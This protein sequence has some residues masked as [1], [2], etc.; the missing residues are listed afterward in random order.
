MEERVLSAG[1][2]ASG[3]RVTAVSELP[4]YR[5]RALRCVHLETGCEVLHLANQDPENLFAFVFRTPPPDDTGVAHI[6]EHAVLCGSRRFPLKD[7]FVVLLQSSMNTFLNALTYPDKTAYPAASRLHKDFFNLLDVYGDAVFFPLLRRE[8]FMQEGHHLEPADPGRPEGELA[9]VGVVLNEMKGAFSSP[10]ALLAQTSLRALFPDT[11]YGH[12]SGGD[13]EQIPELTYQ[14]FKEFHS[15]YYHPSNCRIFLYGDIPTAELLAFLQE[16][17]LSQFRHR[18]VA[19][20]LPEQ[21][22]WSRPRFVERRYPVAPEAPASGRSSVTLSWLTVPATE[23]LDLLAMEVATEALVGDVGSPLARALLESE[24]GEDLSPVTGLTA[25]VRQT[26]FSVGLRGTDP[27]KVEAVEKLVLGTLRRLAKEGIPPERLQAALHRVEFRNR[28][29]RRGGRPYSLR[30]LARAMRGWLHGA[31]PLATLEFRPWMKRLRSLLEE[32]PRLLEE[33]LLAQLADNPHRATVLV[34]P[35]QGLERRRREEERS[36]LAR[37]SAGLSAA[38]RRRLAEEL[39]AMRRF[40]AQRE[41]AD[42]KSGVPTLSIGDL[43]RQVERIPS[44]RRQEA[45]RPL[46]LHDLFTGGIIYLDL[47]FD[48]TGI[49][50]PLSTLVPLFG[51]AVCGSG[52]PGQPYHQT[53]SRLSLLTGGFGAGASAGSHAVSRRAGQRLLFRVKMLEENLEAALEIVFDLL[54]RAD[55]GDL[56]RLEKLVLELRND[57][58]SSLVPAGNHYAALRAASRFSEAAQVEER[59][60]GVTQLARIRDLAASMRRR[61][62]ETA[63]ALRRLR[64]VLVS[65]ERL[66]INLTCP[67]AAAERALAALRPGLRQLP[68]TGA[69]SQAVPGGLWEPEAASVG[70]GYRAEGLAVPAEVG[71]VAAVM[72]AA[73]F[74]TAEHA[75]ETVLGRYL[76]TGPLWERVRM[77]GGAYGAGASADGLE[78]LWTFSSYRDPNPAGT[79]RVF[80]EALSEVAR[81]GVEAGEL[82]RTVI[83]TVGAED[84]PLSPGE[85]G[86]VALNRELAGISDRERQRRREQTLATGPSDLKAAAAR[87]LK[88][89]NASYL[90]VLAGRDALERAGAEIPDLRANL[91]EIPD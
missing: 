11:P 91:V 13:P 84:R 29:I 50:D 75:H 59:W 78:G 44:E 49:E 89:L 69:A 46:L 77:K 73:R 68:A 81:R 72:P 53:A 3:F 48:T 28:E 40:Q 26:V 54:L 88:S 37:L 31:D 52:L 79:W 17:F 90:A 61:P 51:L 5:S 66:T 36:R 42:G 74:G 56:K 87:L 6:I 22:R 2:E 58:K 62:E 45:G 19:S 20:E 7:P 23:P 32:R 25:D 10:E 82:Q 35:E 15:R 86:Y 80:R 16:R 18:E 4:E 71:Y 64:S 27:E 34:R 12:I 63:E 55:F 47:A 41:P 83:G 57:L 33:L 1:S 85:Q 43:P 39:E 65:A 60:S 76:A 8:A 70:D 24:L 38:G 30:L 14:R 9:R 67:A 21:P